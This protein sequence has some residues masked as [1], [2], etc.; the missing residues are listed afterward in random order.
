MKKNQNPYDK[1][2]RKDKQPT[3]NAKLESI[4]S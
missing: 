1:A 4:E 2:A 3:G